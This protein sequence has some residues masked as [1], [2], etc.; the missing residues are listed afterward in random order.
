MRDKDQML[1]A[2]VQSWIN[3]SMRDGYASGGTVR[4]LANAAIGSSNLA[5]QVG[6]SADAVRAIAAGDPS[7]KDL[8][9][10]R[11][12]AAA[13]GYDSP[14]LSQAMGLAGTAK[15]AYNLANDPSGTNAAKLAATANP[16]AAQALGLYNVAANATPASAINFVAGFNPILRAY[17]A[18]ADSFDFANVGR[19]AE[20]ADKI[21]NPE[22]PAKL[23]DLFSNNPNS[24]ALTR[25][26][27]AIAAQTG[28][29]P[30]SALMGLTGAFGT[31]PGYSGYYSNDVTP[32]TQGGGFSLGSHSLGGD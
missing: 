4:D 23:R 15:A 29:D 14:G 2:L 18:L 16:I 6:S 25:D 12:M 1:K 26:A 31:E 22:A 13:L 17:N 19:L 8:N 28:A 32:S 10:L 5:K 21:A 3:D 9:S 20:N 27:N 7:M 30:M 24:N 11:Q